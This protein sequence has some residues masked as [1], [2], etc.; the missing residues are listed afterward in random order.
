MA[1][2]GHEAADLTQISA[3]E[4]ADA[5]P[6]RSHQSQEAHTPGWSRVTLC[7]ERPVGISA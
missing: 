3:L 4:L 2:I 5:T 7:N 6:L 1:A